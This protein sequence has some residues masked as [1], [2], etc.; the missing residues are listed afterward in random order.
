VISVVISQIGKGILNFRFPEKEGFL[1]GFNLYALINRNNALLFDSAFRTQITEVKKYLASEGLQLTHVVLTH[2]HNDHAAGLVSLN[3]N[4]TVLG[5]SEY[6]KTLR[7][8]I[9]QEVTP[10]SFRDEFVFGNFK[11]RFT[12][13]PG[14][15]PCSIFV[16]IN[17]KLLHAGDNLMSRYDGKAILPWVEFDQL[18]N[19]ISSLKILKAMNRD[20]VLVSHGPELVGN[21]TVNSAIDNRLFYLETVRNSSG[22]CSFE[23]AVSGCTCSYMGN[24]FF[25]LLSRKQ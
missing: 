13:A 23:E 24:E 14:H 20:R 21:K 10:V 2:F 16:D 7:K 18:E 22:T 15:S 4:V 11:L 17:G 9:P 19:H 3:R 5:S 8:N 1:Y 12:A 25:Q 6:K